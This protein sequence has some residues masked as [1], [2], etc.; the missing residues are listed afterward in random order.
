MAVSQTIGVGQTL[1]RLRSVTPLPVIAL[2]VFVLWRS[3][4]EVGPFGADVDAA[5]NV[6]GLCVAALGQA[7]RFY[8]LSWV[9][10]GTSGQGYQ[11]EA[12]VLNTK[13]PYAHVRNP[14]YLGNLGIV[15]G[16]LLIA[17]NLWAYLLGLG[18]FFGE[19]FFIIRA[20]EAFLRGQ[21][22]AAFDAYVK[23]VPR[24]VP[25]LT[26]AS[27]GHLRDGHFDWKRGFKKEHNP[28]AAW[29][30]GALGLYA[31]EWHA[32]GQLERPTLVYLLA[33]QMAVLLLFVGIKGWKHQWLKRA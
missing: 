31:W 2:L 4:A 32:R 28:F 7:L 22:G 21:F 5:L 33:A 3:R 8:T 13:G 16:L 10:E 24:W 17:H 9:P 30:S 11:L 26:A 20:E 19:Y 29:A 27:R 6:L 15:L 1:F 18:F 25:R 14:L 12:K 23:Q